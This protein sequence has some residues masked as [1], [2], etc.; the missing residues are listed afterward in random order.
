MFCNIIYSNGY[1]MT[2][3]TSHRILDFIYFGRAHGPVDDGIICYHSLVH[4]VKGKQIA[5]WRP[6][7]A[8]SYS[9]FITM[10]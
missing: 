1:F 6:I 9:E 2:F 8:F 3:I 5:L 7:C 10:Y 4:P